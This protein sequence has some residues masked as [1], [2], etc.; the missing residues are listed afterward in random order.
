MQGVSSPNK[1]SNICDTIDSIKRFVRDLFGSSN[2][3]SSPFDHSK[4]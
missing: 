3:T 1:G 2:L 4:L